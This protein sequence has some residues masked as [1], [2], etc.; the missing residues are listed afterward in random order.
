MDENRSIKDVH[1]KFFHGKHFKL[2]REFLSAVFNEE[3]DNV[4]RTL[5]EVR[6]S[7][8]RTY[9]R[10]MLEI[11]KIIVPKQGNIRVDHV[12]H[13]LDELMAMG[14]GNDR[15][16]I[17]EHPQ[18]K[19]NIEEVPWENVIESHPDITDMADAFKMKRDDV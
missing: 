4:R 2:P 13:D 9:L 3:Q 15:P 12:N 8:P 10:T 14:R 18:I 1:D 19:E 11:A 16:L 7:D 5:D 6:M 17:T